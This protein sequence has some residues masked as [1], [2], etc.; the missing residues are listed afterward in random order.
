MNRLHV[1]FTTPHTMNTMIALLAT[2][3]TVA[4]A[5]GVLYLMTVILSK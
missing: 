1:F 3:A 4:V 2:V 5:V